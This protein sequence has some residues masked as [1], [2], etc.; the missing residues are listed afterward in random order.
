MKIEVLRYNHDK[1]STSG[2][3]AIDGAFECFTLEDERREV[4][5]KGSTR[6][7]DG[8]YVVGF[9]D[10]LTPMTASYQKRFGWFGKHLHIKA[11]PN[12]T[13]VYIHIGNYEKDTAG[14]LLVADTAVND[15][16]DYASIQ[17]NSTVAFKRLYEK[18]SAALKAGLAVTLVIKTIW[19]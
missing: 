12:F 14:C 1:K 13:G 9:Q 10:I 16:K 17:Q 2:I 7:P 11:V 8:V 3:L 5:V 6:I 4:K 18:V 19:Q 15:P